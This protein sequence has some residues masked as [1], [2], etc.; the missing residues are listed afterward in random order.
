MR[1]CTI[2]IYCT[3]CLRLPKRAPS[4]CNRLQ[5]AYKF[6]CR[7][8]CAGNARASRHA[9]EQGVRSP[10]HS[11]SFSSKAKG[12][13]VSSHSDYQL[14]TLQRQSGTL[15]GGSPSTR[16]ATANHSLRFSICLCLTTRR[17]LRLADGEPNGPRRKP[18][19]SNLSEP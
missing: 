10:I 17:A 3:D 7:T 18:S 6:L 19:I 5:P 8:L 1:L 4:W 12:F 15:I 13:D 14:P 9:T 11:N 16:I 2:C